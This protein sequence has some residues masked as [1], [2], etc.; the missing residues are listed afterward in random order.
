MYGRLTTLRMHHN[1]YCNTRTINFLS[2]AYHIAMDTITKRF[3]CGFKTN[4]RNLVPYSGFCLQGP[5]S[6]KHQFLCPA[7]ISVISIAICE[8]ILLPK[9]VI[10]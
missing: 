3:N 2:T 1:I 7:V 5:I 8:V 4:G 9:N 6:V 10:S